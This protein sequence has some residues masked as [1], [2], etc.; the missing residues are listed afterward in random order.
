M[1]VTCVR[2]ISMELCSQQGDCDFF[3]V[4]ELLALFPWG[5]IFHC[6]SRYVRYSKICLYQQFALSKNT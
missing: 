6:G 3:V 2:L 4:E 1:G 5:G